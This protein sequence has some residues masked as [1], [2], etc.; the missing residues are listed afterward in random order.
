MNSLGFIYFKISNLYNYNI[1]TS[2]HD[3]A[4]LKK[5]KFRVDLSLSYHPTIIGKHGMIC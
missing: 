5:Y 1:E 4:Y 2:L 3:G